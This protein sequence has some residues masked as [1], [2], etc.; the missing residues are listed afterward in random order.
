MSRRTPNSPLGGQPRWVAGDPDAG[1]ATTRT[2]FSKAIPQGWPEILTQEGPKWNRPAASPLPICVAVERKPSSLELR[3]SSLQKILEFP[4]T[5]FPSATSIFLIDNFPRHVGA[6]FSSHLEILIA[7][8][9]KIRNR[10]NLL[11]TNER[12][13]F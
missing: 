6:A 5:R 12:S 9:W 2:Q 1:G 10:R 13:Q 11:K 3:A 8:L 4:L 7:D